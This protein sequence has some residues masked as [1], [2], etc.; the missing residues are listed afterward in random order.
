MK[1]ETRIKNFTPLLDDLVRDYGVITAAVWGRVWRYAQQENRVCQA[2][3][4]KIAAELAISRRTVIRHLEILTQDGYLLD[5]TPELKNRP[6]TYSITEKARILITIEGV[7]E[8]HSKHK[9]GVT[10]SHGTVTESH[11]SVTE[12]HSHGDRESHEE[13]KK[14]QIKRQE[15]ER[16]S[17]A[18]S[19][20]DVYKAYEKEIG[21]LT[22]SISNVLELALEDYPVEWFISAFEQAAR[23]NKR[24]WSYAEAILKRWKREGFQSQNKSNKNGNGTGRD[25]VKNEDGS[26]YV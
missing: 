11:T 19:V 25:V 17:P 24:S 6:H 18:A 15:E 1:A 3:Q 20:G 21:T 13:T 2:S 10:E 8:S 22:P 26:M 16:K 7:T 14:K 4:D 12:S 9:V 5:H 23:N